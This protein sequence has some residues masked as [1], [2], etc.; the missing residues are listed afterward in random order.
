MRSFSKNKFLLCFRPIDAMLES[1][2][3]SHRSSTCRIPTSE[4][5]DQVMKM[6]NSQ[7]KSVYFHHASPKRTISRVVKAVFF[8]TLLNRKGHHKNRYIH[9]S[10]KAKYLTYPERKALQCS[11]SHRSSQ[12]KKFSDYNSIIKGKKE[13]GVGVPLENKQQKKLQW[14]A[15]YLLLISLVFTV[16]WGKFFGIILTSIWLYFS[17]MWDSSSRG[18]KRL[19]LHS[20]PRLRHRGHYAR[21]EA[22]TTIMG[23]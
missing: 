20:C 16:V 21:R 23:H 18:Q 2:V 14:H 6:K 9:D 17:S 22:V 11:S 19:H 15:I 5:H 10:F 13:G 12:P 7:T 1:E 3:S 4:K 8:E